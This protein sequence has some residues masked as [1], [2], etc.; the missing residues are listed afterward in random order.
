MAKATKAGTSRGRGA[1][2][3]VDQFAAFQGMYDYFNGALFG[4]TLHPVILNFSRAAGSLGFFAPERWEQGA[5]TTHEISL[6]PAHL[7]TRD[8]RDVAS[9]LVHEMAHCW[10]QEHGTPSARGYHNKEWA[11]KMDAIGLVPSATGEPGGPRVGFKMTHYIADGGPFARAFARMPRGFL[12][13]W[14]SWEPD[15]GRK[16]KGPSPKSKTKYTCPRCGAN[17]WGKPE[18]HLVCGD[19]HTRMVAED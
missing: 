11:A 7:A 19:D 10:Q 15:G 6:N 16:K 2:P 12:L 18:L 14:S 5:R 4:G 17:A 1:A 8:A 3:T 13:P 9:T